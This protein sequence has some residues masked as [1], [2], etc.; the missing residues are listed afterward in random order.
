MKSTISSKSTQFQFFNQLRNTLHQ[1]FKFIFPGK[2]T[3]NLAT[4]PHAKDTSKHAFGTQ[5]ALNVHITC[6]KKNTLRRLHPV[7]SLMCG[8][9]TGSQ[10]PR[11]SS[12]GLRPGLGYC[13]LFLGTTL[14]FH[15]ALLHP[16]VH[17]WVPVNLMLRV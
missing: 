3:R 10:M 12:L 5:T 6:S 4:G 8:A 13:V 17:K 14:Y 15:R 1:D 9:H 16:D 11:L 2:D 7:V